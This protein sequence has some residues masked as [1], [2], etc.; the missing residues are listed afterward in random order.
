MKFRSSYV[1]SYCTP[2]MNCGGGRS[3]HDHQTERTT[4]GVR[5]RRVPVASGGRPVVR[6]ERFGSQGP[7]INFRNSYV[8]R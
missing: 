7:G 4:Y 3:R 6:F 1:G 2:S 8:I 5:F